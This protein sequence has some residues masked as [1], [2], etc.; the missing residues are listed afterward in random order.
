MDLD[1]LQ[2]LRDLQTRPQAERYQ[3][4]GKTQ[5]PHFAQTLPQCV[6][7]AQLP[8]QSDFA[9]SGQVAGYGLVPKAG[10][11]CHVRGQIGGRL[12]QIQ[13]A[14]HIDVGV[15]DA[16]PQPAPLLQHSQQKIGPI[17][18]KTV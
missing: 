6:Y 18:V 10:G 15:A 5:A 3:A 11:L 1:Q 14:D 13:S 12:I 4:L 8:G 16:Y 9:H 17:I 2:S 7:R